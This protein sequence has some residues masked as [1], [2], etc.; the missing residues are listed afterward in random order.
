MVPCAEEGFVYGVPAFKYKG[1]NLVCYAA[2][3]KHCG[4]YPFSPEIIETFSKE[5]ERFETSKGTIRFTNECQIPN[6]LLSRMIDA[7]IKELE[8][9]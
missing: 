3:K 1:K 2:F 6:E 9:K 4:F 5:L 8:P 7:R